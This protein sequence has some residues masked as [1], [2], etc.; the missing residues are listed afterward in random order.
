[1]KGETL[2]WI[3]DLQTVCVVL[4]CALTVILQRIMVPKNL[5]GRKVD[6]RDIKSRTRHGVFDDDVNKFDSKTGKVSKQL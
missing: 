4:D 2:I 5:E 6:S 1:M 3:R